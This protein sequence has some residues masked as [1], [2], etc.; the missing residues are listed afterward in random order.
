[1][2]K[3]VT[4]SAMTKIERFR[5]WFWWHCE[6]LWLPINARLHAL[7]HLVRGHKVRWYADPDL[8]TGHLGWIECVDCPDTKDGVGLVIWGRHAVWRMRIAQW[9]CGKLGHR[10]YQHPYMLSEP[11]PDGE[12]VKLYQYHVWHCGRCLADV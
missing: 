3:S 8:W 2:T 10:D 9:I 6:G 4:K 7:W 11:G 1:V 12:H 5:W